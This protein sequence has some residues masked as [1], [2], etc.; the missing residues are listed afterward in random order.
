M[1][2]KFSKAKRPSQ[3]ETQWMWG[4]NPVMELLEHAPHKVLRLCLAKGLQGSR[5]ELL[6]HK[7]QGAKVP[8][9]W[10]ER[11]EL[12]MWTGNAVHQ[13]VMAEVS[14][15]SFLSEEALLELVLPPREDTVVLLLDGVE[16]PQNLGAI[17]RSALALGASALVIGKNRSVG[18]TPAVLKASAGAWVYLPVAQVTNLSRLLVRL[19]KEG[20]WTLAA[21]P[22]A[23][24]ALWELDARGPWGVVVG[25]EGRG[26][27]PNLLGHCD[28]QVQIPM[29]GQLSSLN[30]SVSAGIVLYE[31]FRQ[32]KTGGA[33]LTKNS[34]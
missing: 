27:G 6:A 33:G 3:K 25:G 2:G 24:T 1:K 30:A 18:V 11:K 32:R 13:G 22:G 4:L 26:I 7:A 10:T 31:L 12:D 29:L 8:V 23:S 20:Y 5:L 28:L 17:A 15:F 9:E 14:A 34:T 19:K 16:D 21:S